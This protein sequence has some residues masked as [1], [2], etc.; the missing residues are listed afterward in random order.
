[1]TV[2]GELYF[3]LP[4]PVS[5]ELTVQARLTHRVTIVILPGIPSAKAVLYWVQNWLSLC[6][7]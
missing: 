6:T 3:I 1:M 2:A 4:F 5:V 7:E